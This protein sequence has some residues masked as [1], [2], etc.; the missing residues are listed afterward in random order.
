MIVA[1]L[2]V[3]IG[4]PVSLNAVTASSMVIALLALF[5]NANAAVTW[6]AAADVPLKEE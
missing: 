3:E 5:N 6:G 2:F 1:V 4:I